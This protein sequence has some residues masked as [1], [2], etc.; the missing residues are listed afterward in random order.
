VKTLVQV[1]IYRW[2]D[3]QLEFLLL[4]RADSKDT[5]WQPV[6][7][8]ME[9]SGNVGDTL[10]RE[11][12]E[13]TGIRKFKDLTEQLYTYEWYSDDQR[14]KGN[15]LVFGAE[16]RP[17]TE[18]KLDPKKHDAF[19]WLPYEEA[20]RRLKWDGNKESLRRLYERLQGQQTAGPVA[21]S[22]DYSEDPGF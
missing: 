15:D 13:E 20:L 4:K 6:T 17:D 9:P 8:H 11:V 12:I 16:V 10:K 7:G 21:G 22:D 5:Y 14:E 1:N 3:G 18:V 19:E 2:R